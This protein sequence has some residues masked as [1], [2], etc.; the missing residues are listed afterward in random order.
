MNEDQV[1]LLESLR[2][3]KFFSLVWPPWMSSNIIGCASALFV[4]PRLLPPTSKV[5][6]NSSEA[7]TASIKISVLFG[8]FTSNV[9]VILSRVSAV[10]IAT[11][12]GLD[13]RGVG[14]QVPVGS[15]IF[16]SPRR[17]DHLWVPPSLLSKSNGYRGGFCPGVKRPGR[18][19]DHS[20][21][22]SAEVKK[23]WIYTSSPHTPSWR[24]A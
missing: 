10:G 11:G 3:A 22:T 5:L 21:P 24:T 2:S 9:A 4:C 20:P 17:P 7:W 1:C 14:V 6:N 13:D 12:Y 23:T 18:E 15:N 8:F 16:S 19:A